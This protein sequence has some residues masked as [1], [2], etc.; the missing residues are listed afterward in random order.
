MSEVDIVLAAETGRTRVGERLGMKPTVTDDS[1][2]SFR[3]QG[4]DEKRN[5]LYRDSEQVRSSPCR[6]GFMGRQ[7][8]EVVENEHVYQPVSGQGR[9]LGRNFMRTCS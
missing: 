3:F 4:L 6:F 9:R 5:Q 1:G 8:T 2:P 7:V